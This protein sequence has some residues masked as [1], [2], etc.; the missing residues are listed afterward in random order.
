M[1]MIRL[2]L[3]AVVVAGGCADPVAT[4]Y[5]ASTTTAI[6]VSQC[7][8]TRSVVHGVE[9]RNA[10]TLAQRGDPAA[11]RTA[12]DAW[13]L[14][15]NIWGQVCDAG[16][17]AVAG[18]V[19]QS[20]SFETAIDKRTAIAPWIDALGKALADMTAKIAEFGGVR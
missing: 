11:A 2:M 18:F 19:A 6:A 16:A 1:I 14:K 13:L 5:K 17:A 3:L 9:Q 15:Y 10:Q 7:Y 8:K 12:Q 4:V 20:K